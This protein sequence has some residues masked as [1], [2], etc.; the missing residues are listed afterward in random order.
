[1]LFGAG[2]LLGA[3]AVSADVLSPGLSATAAG[4]YLRPCGDVRISDSWQ[5]HKNR[6]PPSAEPGTDYAV[7]VGTAVR[8]ATDGV[9]ID[10]KDSTSTATGRYLALRADDGNYLR[11][12]HLLSSIVAVGTRVT[13]GQ[14][15]AY[16]GASGF[17]SENGYG[18]HVHVSLWVNG[19]PSQQGFAASVDFE[20]YVVGP[21]QPSE[22]VKYYVTRY[23]N[24]VW[25]VT[26]SAI[27]PLTFAQWQ[28]AGSPPPFSAPTDY[29]RYPWSTT[30]SAVTMFGTPQ[31]RWI[32]RHL[33]LDEWNRVGR[34]TPRI[35]GWI[36]DSVYYQWAGSSQIFVQDA[37]GVKHALTYAEWQASG[38]QPF[39][40]RST[41]GF[42]KLSWD[43]N[44]A[45]LT[46]F[47]AGKGGPIT[48]KQWAAEG[49]PT[50]TVAMRFPGDQLYKFNGDP[51]I[52][53][54]GPTVNRP[55]TYAEWGML[56]Y[57]TPTIR[58]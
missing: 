23:D 2:T 33:T 41:Q 14:V 47:A 56:G 30:I 40:K 39:E 42:V 25:A 44:I 15:I 53:Y 55:I 21:T 16:S 27:I 6:N 13:R 35:A 22:P 28:A 7:E 12:L 31:S 29:V 32:W 48:Q 43:G 8:A 5:G 18:A 38:F 17:G 49:Y 51:T 24:T 10:R 11:Y 37:G 4:T 34:P 57:P 20:N 36:K 1:M 58:R 46:D 45:F 3:A 26:P 50:P 54:A 52:W 9:I 19:T